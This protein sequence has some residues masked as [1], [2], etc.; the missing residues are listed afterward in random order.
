MLLQQ[1]RVRVAHI[2]EFEGIFDGDFVPAGQVVHEELDEVEEV[3]RFKSSFVENASFVH[4]SELVFVDF[5]IKVLI[6]FPDPLIYF[7]LAVGETQFGQH[8]NH[9]FLVDGQSR[10]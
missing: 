8:S 5:S 2:D 4:E 7:W 3:A 9:V 6:Y 10:C 1:V